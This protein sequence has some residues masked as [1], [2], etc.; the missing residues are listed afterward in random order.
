VSATLLRLAFL[1]GSVGFWDITGGMVTKAWFYCLLLACLVLGPSGVGG[2][3]P[4]KLRIT[5]TG[6]ITNHLGVNLVQFK[7]EVEKHSAGEISIEIFDNSRLYKD[8]QAVA[9]VTSGAI[10]MGTIGL[11]Q[12][13]REEPA[14][15]LFTQPFLLNFEALVRAATDP[16]REVRKVLDKALLDRFGVRVLWLQSF[17]NSVFFSKGGRDARTPA[18][19]QGQKVRSWA[20][21]MSRFT[22]ACGGTP[23]VVSSS[24]LFQAAK[25]GSVDM[26]MSGITMVDTRELW[27]V[28]DTVTRTEHAVLEFA[29]VINE[30]VW[31][32][33]GDRHKAVITAAGREAEREL[34]QTIAAIEEKAYAF[35]RSKDMKVY[36]LTPNEVAEWRAC[37]AEVMDEFMDTAGETGRRLMEAYGKLRTD[38]CCSAGPKGEFTSR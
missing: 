8:D 1:D 13:V 18:G 35:A 10:E 26:V 5:A 30:K 23:V 32:S 38:S 37:S 34:R 24:K 6:P 12:F 17:G 29:V 15:E 14:L 31:Q 33:L 11:S 16:D 3:E 2:A 36:D 25:D 7:K 19:I 27:K 21:N 4:V 28:M 22:T 20:K 9:A